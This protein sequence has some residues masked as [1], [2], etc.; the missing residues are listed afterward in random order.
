MCTPPAAA[1]ALAAAE[2]LS[3]HAHKDYQHI[4]DTCVGEQPQPAVGDCCPCCE[5]AIGGG[6]D[7]RGP[8]MWRICSPCKQKWNRGRKKRGGVPLGGRLS[9]LEAAAARL[10]S[11]AKTA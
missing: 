10:Q 8:N 11:D 4:M 9:C 5:Q 7:A 6:Q 2:A 1:A 3:K